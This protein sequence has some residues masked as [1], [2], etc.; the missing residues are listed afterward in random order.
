MLKRI[1]GLLGWLGV[2]LVFSAVRD[3]VPEAGVGLVQ[4][5]GDGWTGLHA[6]LHPQPM[7]GDGPGDVGA[8]GALRVAG[9]CQRPRRSCHPR[10]DQ[11]P[12]GTPQQAV[13]SDGREAI[14]VVRA[15]TESPAEPAEAGSPQSLRDVGRIR[16]VF[17]SGSTSSSTRLHRYPSSTSTPSSARHSP[18]ST[19]SKRWARS[20]S[21]T[22]GASS[23]SRRTA[24]RS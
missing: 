23:G 18:I 2:A 15:D 8:R 24:S 16:A 22:K 13:G 3:S 12:V 9:G 1:L 21:S 11:L 7:A 10:R 19:R 20:S 5:A 4:P 6:A 17:A 14:H